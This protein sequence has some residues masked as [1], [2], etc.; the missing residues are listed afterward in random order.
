MTRKKVRT[1]KDQLRIERTRGFW[2]TKGEL[3]F[4]DDEA[5]REL[6]SALGGRLREISGKLGGAPRH[7][8][9]ER[10]PCGEMTLKRAEARRH[11]CAK[12]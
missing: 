8:G 7:E 3:I 2:V 5:M 9:K 10:C 4:G 12:R 1:V 11:Q 6:Y